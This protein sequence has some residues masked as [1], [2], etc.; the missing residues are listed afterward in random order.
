MRYHVD[1]GGET[2]LVERTVDGATIDGRPVSFESIRLAPDEV[3]IRL[4]LRGWRITAVR[5]AEGWK[6]AAAGLSFDIVVEDERSR[7]IRELTGADSG[8]PASS[9]LKAPMPGLVVKVF[10][11]PGQAVTL[12]DPL[13]VVE[14]MKMENE[15]RA[16]GAGIVSDVV[17]GAGDTVRRDDVL[18]RFA[19]PE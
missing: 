16:G 12:G 6:L 13:V 3:H 19:A 4:G 5:L 10:V 9:D 7:V 15:L 1:L 14:A 17:V 2:H 11:E 8:R 18:V